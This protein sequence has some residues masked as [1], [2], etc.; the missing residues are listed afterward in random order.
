VSL[1]R[2]G[3][4]LAAYDNVCIGDL[5]TTVGSCD[6]QGVFFDR[7]QL[8]AKGFVQGERGTVPGTDLAFDVPAIPAGQPDNATGDG[9]TIELEV[10]AD[11][12]QLSVIGTGTEKN[13]QAQGVLT[14]DDG[15]S[16]PIDLSFGDWSGAARNP[17]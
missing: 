9:Q 7:A 12:E 10:P 16:Q 5:G 13:Q 2:E 6:G 3:S 11:A 15:S 4:L 14:F 1:L 17:V 8:A